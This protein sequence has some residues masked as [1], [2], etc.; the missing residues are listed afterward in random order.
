MDA[1]MAVLQTAHRAGEGKKFQLLPERMD[2]ICA[3]CT[4]FC[5]NVPPRWGLR[6]IGNA[7]GYKPVAP[8]ALS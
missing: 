3:I 4:N 2:T 5:R 1:G 6:F 7:T 8:L